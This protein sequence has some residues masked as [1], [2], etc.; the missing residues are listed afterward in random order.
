MWFLE[1][2]TLWIY[3]MHIRSPERV[4][5]F[6]LCPNALHENLERVEHLEDWAHKTNARS[7]RRILSEAQLKEKKISRRKARTRKKDI[8]RLISSRKKGY[9]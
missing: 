6:R 7:K 9:W 1:N 2:F 8:Q 5:E 4:E 3:R